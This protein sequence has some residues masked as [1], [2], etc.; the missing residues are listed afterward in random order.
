LGVWRRKGRRT[1]EEKNKKC[2]VP[3]YKLQ[4]APKK[5]KEKSDVPTY[6]FFEIS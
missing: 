5:K 3:T 2:D 4:G 1:A 6:L